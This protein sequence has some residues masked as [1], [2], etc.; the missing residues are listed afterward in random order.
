MFF[1]SPGCWKARQSCTFYGRAP[2]EH[3]DAH[4]RGKIAHQNQRD[5]RFLNSDVVEIEGV[6]F[7][8][9]KASGFGCNCL[10]DSLRQLLGLPGDVGVVSQVRAMLRQEYATP[11]PDFVGELNYLTL[12]LHWAAAVRCLSAATGGEV[13]PE[14]VQVVCVTEAHGEANGMVEGGGPRALHVLNRGN[15]HFD[16]LFPWQ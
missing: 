6:V 14:G 16:P 5:V 11:G 4:A 2:L 10:I 1:P 7:R 3:P 12:D 9:K 15:N 8:A 13:A